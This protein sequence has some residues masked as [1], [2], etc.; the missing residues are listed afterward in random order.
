MYECILEGHIGIPFDHRFGKGSG[1]RYIYTLI[2]RFFGLG[3]NKGA[4]PITD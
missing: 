2:A 3:Y 1:L 4:K